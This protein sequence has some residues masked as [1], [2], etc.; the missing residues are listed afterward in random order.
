MRNFQEI[1]RALNVVRESVDERKEAKVIGS[2]KY[3][4]SKLSEPLPR[5][6]TFIWVIEL[7]YVRCKKAKRIHSGGK[8]GTK[9]QDEFLMARV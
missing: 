5:S 8:E 4:V 1:H 2:E 9:L 6:R 7:S 3:S